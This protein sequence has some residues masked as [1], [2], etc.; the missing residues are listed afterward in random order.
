M[1][2]GLTGYKGCG[3]STVAAYLES[4]HGFVRIRFADPLK[5]MLR[6]LGLGDR[7]IEG[8]LK[9]APCAALNG[10]TPRHAMQTLGTEWGRQMIDPALWTA[11]WRRRVESAVATG[12][13]VVAEDLR[14]LNEAAELA[15]A[16]GRVW[17]IDRPGCSAGDH[18]SEVEQD[19]IAFELGIVNHSDIPTLQES[20]DSALNFVGWGAKV[21]ES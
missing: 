9:E 5:D 4:E 14:F 7:E 12:N 21:T 6:R 19:S 2:L 17:R 10:R 18:V 15:E 11:A 3:K 8:D 20:V 16:G 13:P 1:I